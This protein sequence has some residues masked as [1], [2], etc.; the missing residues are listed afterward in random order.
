MS[1]N[2]FK[3]VLNV[4]KTKCNIKERW[5]DYIHWRFQRDHGRTSVST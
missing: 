1:R 4:N 2:R 5:E 3:D